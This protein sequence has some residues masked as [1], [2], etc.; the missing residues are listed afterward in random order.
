MTQTTYALSG[1]LH[2]LLWR[3]CKVT[4]IQDVPSNMKSSSRKWD[5][6]QSDV[7]CITGPVQTSREP[8]DLWPFA[9]RH[10]N[11]YRAV[12]L[13]P[14]YWIPR[15][16]LHPSYKPS[17]SLPAPTALVAPTVRTSITW[18]CLPRSYAD[19]RKRTYNSSSRKS[20]VKTTSKYL[21]IRPPFNS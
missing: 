9:D 17:P 12:R 7:Y 21:I 1:Y 18:L 11:I 5:I 4:W 19:A 2:V 14:L 15:Y 10:W 13:I 3:L 6:W 20:E 8:R 16:P